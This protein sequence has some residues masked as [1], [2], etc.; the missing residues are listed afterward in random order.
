MSEYEY[1][2]C[3]D[4]IG[5]EWKLLKAEARKNLVWLKIRTF[6]VDDF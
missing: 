6:S 1:S 5:G 2:L 3:L 4:W